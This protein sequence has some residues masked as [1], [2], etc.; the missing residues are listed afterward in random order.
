MLSLNTLCKRL[1]IDGRFIHVRVI[2]IP[3][4]EYVGSASVFPPCE[5][6]QKSHRESH[7]HG[8]RRYGQKINAALFGNHRGK[9]CRCRD[10]RRYGGSLNFLCTGLLRKAENG[11][12]QNRA[13]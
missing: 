12:D 1:V 11:Y 13:D 6:Q 8:K 7:N 9:L 5:A 4:L 2:G 10:L 3:A